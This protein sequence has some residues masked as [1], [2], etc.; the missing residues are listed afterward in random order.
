LQQ[1]QRTVC[2]TCKGKRFI[3]EDVPPALRAEDV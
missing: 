1:A 3:G 2:E